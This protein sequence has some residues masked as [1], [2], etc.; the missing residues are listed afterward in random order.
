[1][2][3]ATLFRRFES[4]RSIMRALG[5]RMARSQAGRP[6]VH[7]SPS[8]DTHATLFAFA[9]MEIEGAM[10]DGGLAMRLAYD[11]RSVPE[12]GEA[13]SGIEQL[14]DLFWPGASATKER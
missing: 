9:R 12:V 3:E 14:F 4:K 7:V 10:A 13:P 5:E 11:A 6:A 8:G 1:M 2:N